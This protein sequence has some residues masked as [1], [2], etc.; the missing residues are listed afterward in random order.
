MYIHF[1]CEH[2]RERDHLENLVIDAQIKIKLVLKTTES[3]GM[4]WVRL[5]LDRDE[6]QA[7]LNT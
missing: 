4:K 6:V 1:W 3:Y 5:P 7:L 2:L